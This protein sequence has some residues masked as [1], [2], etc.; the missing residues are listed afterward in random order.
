[1]G[2]CDEGRSLKWYAHHT[3]SISNELTSILV[4]QD[5]YFIEQHS[6]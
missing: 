6:L 3:K 1:M 4:I 5:D 2:A